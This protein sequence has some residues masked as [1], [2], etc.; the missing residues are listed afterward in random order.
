MAGGRAACLWTVPCPEPFSQREMYSV[1][2][3]AP[4]CV[5]WVGRGHSPCSPAAATPSCVLV[6]P[7][8]VLKWLRRLA[9]SGSEHTHRFAYPRGPSCCIAGLGC[10]IACWDF[11]PCQLHLNPDFSPLWFAA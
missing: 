1:P 3:A 6:S 10:S 9:G 2:V 7:T 11:S 5:G 8:P 4:A